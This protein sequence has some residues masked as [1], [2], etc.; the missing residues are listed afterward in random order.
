[1]GEDCRLSHA[2]VIMGHFATARAAAA[3]RGAKSGLTWV[4]G[5]QGVWLAWLVS[6]SQ[7]PRLTNLTPAFA[8]P[9]TSVGYYVLSSPQVAGLILCARAATTGACLLSA[10]PDRRMRR[11][12]ALSNST[13]GLELWR[14][15][16]LPCIDS[17]WGG[18]L[19]AGGWSAGASG[20]GFVLLHPVR[21]RFRQ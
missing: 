19:V 21:L 13:A 7:A 12:L 10:G 20:M 8:Y 15:A 1:M 16:P 4:P 5:P 3:G 11:A 17:P 18:W 9:P 2:E 6:N 14:C